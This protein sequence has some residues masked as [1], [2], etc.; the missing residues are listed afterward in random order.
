[1]RAR[2]K[3][4]P[5]LDSS[6]AAAASYSH[7]RALALALPH[8]EPASVEA[9]AEDAHLLKARGKSLAP[10]GEENGRTGVAVLLNRVLQQLVRSVDA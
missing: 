2:T 7:A 4:R 1:M 10:A 8:G 5:L 6:P 9:A 3:R